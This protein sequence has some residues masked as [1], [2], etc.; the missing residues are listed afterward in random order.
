MKT[1]YIHNGGINYMWWIL[2][3]VSFILAII[4]NYLF[5]KSKKLCSIKAFVY[6]MFWV[7]EIRNPKNKH[8]FGF[9]FFNFA[10]RFFMYP[11]VF[12]TSFY[13]ISGVLTLDI[14]AIIFSIIML[15]IWPL[16]YRLVMGLQRKMHGI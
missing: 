5:Y 4:F 7:E 14:Q 12:F 1:T 13:F 16:G 2:I 9:K 15:I 11:Y 8:K 6:K 10:V 3:L